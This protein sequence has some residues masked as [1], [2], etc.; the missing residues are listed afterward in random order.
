MAFGALLG[1]LGGGL[2][3]LGGLLGGT[4]QALGGQ[5]AT[6]TDY[7]SGYRYDTGTASTTADWYSSTIGSI[8][9]YDDTQSATATGDTY[10]EWGSP[11]ATN[12]HYEATITTI[13]TCTIVSE[14]RP[15]EIWVDW[16][17]ERRV[18]RVERQNRDF[19]EY[20]REHRENRRSAAEE[21]AIAEQAARF[22][23]RRRALE[24]QHA[25]FG[26]LAEI[27]AQLGINLEGRTLEQRRALVAAVQAQQ[28]AQ[29]P[30]DPLELLQRQSM[31]DP[32]GAENNINP[33]VAIGYQAGQA[34]GV[35]PN[36]G[37]GARPADP[38]VSKE[39]EKAEEIAQEMLGAMIGEAE[40]E[41]YKKTG[42]LYVKG[43]HADYIVPMSG[44]IQRIEKNRVLDLCVHLAER[45]KYPT[46]DNIIAMKMML[47][48]KESEV[49]KLAN[50]HGTHRRK[51]ITI[52][53]AACM[54]R[55]AA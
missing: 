44:H 2:G 16:V 22:G 53:P 17:G 40:L 14:V 45:Y 8:Q 26:R 34:R 19:A 35:N 52:L 32:Q 41:V 47:E 43:E 37:I 46:T 15:S 39:K 29:Q 5:M 42:R 10:Y 12:G 50:T 20:Y 1:G 30:I 24:Q 6:T 38:I 27:G 54:E 28:Q 18:D 36:V 23:A 21:M 3:A 11:S 31:V 7:Y 13:P 55:Q 9:Y 4:G 49:M 33:N 51:D 48:N 25:E